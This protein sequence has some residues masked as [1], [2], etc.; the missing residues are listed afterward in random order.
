MWKVTALPRK[1]E[2]RRGTLD[3]SSVPAQGVQQHQAAGVLGLILQCAFDSR[4]CEPRR[5]L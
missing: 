5:H 4:G 3:V 1:W 2:E